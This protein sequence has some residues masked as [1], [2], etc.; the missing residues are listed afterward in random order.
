MERL[1]KFFNAAPTDGHRLDASLVVS[2]AA[3]RGYLPQ[4]ACCTQEVLD[5]VRSQEMNP[6]STF[7]KT[8]EDV[9]S[10]DRFELLID[11][12]LHYASTYGTDYEG[13]V[14]CPNG[15]PIEINY[16]T[17]TVI[18]AVS[19]KEMFDMCVD[20]INAG[21]ALATD[22]LKELV[23]YIVQNVRKHHFA[24]DLDAIA[25][26][27]ALCMISDALG[28]LPNTGAAIVRVLFF[29]VFGTPMPIQG[30]KQLNALLGNR[31]CQASTADLSGVDLR[32][33]TD[34]QLIELSKVFRRYRKFLLGLKR[35]DR[36]RAAINKIR[37]LSDKYHEPMKAG[38]WENLTNLTEKEV[39]S[40]LDSEIVKLD[41][42]FKITRLIQMIVLRKLQ[43]SN[44]TMRVYHI[45]NGRTWTDKNS[46]AP[47][48]A[49]LNDVGRA[50]VKKLVFNLR[51]KMMEM[52][53]GLPVY[54][55]FPQNLNLVCPV[56]E[57]KFFG[58]IPF[59]SSFD[60]NGLNNYFGVYWRNEW[61]TRDFDLH[62][63]DDNGYSIGWNSQ[64]YDQGK[65]CIFSGDMTNANPEATEIFY[66]DGATKVPD[67][68]IV[69]NRFNGDD[70]SKYR[71]F[72]GHE[73]ITHLTKGYMVDP[74]SIQVAEE[75][76]STAQEQ[77]VGRVQDN[78]V[79][80]VVE[81]VQGGIVSIPRTELN[82]AYSDM[83]KSFL[84]LKPVLLAAGFVEYTDEHAQ[85]GIEPD[86]DLTDLRKDTLL[87]LFS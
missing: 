34:Q 47:Y 57:K 56:S 42:N 87:N 14:Y 49:W 59:G 4:T 28:V 55:K 17:Y 71:I 86:I 61:G 18:R 30:H 50:L 76:Y 6:N 7:Y 78:R 23:D 68:M 5:F 24:I 22:T 3:K 45:R 77:I 9:A 11:Q 20:C 2:E 70:N 80:L 64:Y 81:D 83:C 29:K 58:N 82:K 74:N 75:Y 10:K 25:N 62:F 44:K 72:F 39:M 79:Y 52:H 51:Y 32:K 8:I 37:R 35:A 48:G 40:R 84:D 36:N 43:N 73:K 33:L 54:V 1:I 67:G 60:F 38:F 85:D 27:D 46:I 16:K 63:N 65:T 31:H 12:L 19:P 66:F 21:A 41:N 69:L 13:E 53:N 26:R 15:D